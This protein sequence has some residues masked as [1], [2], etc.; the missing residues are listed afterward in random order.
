[1][2]EVP[3]AAA[4]PGDI[5]YW[6]GHVGLFAGDGM[7]IDAGSTRRQIAEPRVGFASRL[8]ASGG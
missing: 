7:V 5:L 8:P 3:L 6:P 2:A 1:M 4:L